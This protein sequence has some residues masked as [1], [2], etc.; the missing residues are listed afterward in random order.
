ME[1]TLLGADKIELIK[2]FLSPA[3]YAGI[4]ERSYR[5]ALCAVEDD[6]L[7]G[8]GIFDAKEAAVIHDIIVLD[9]L[10]GE[11]E[12]DIIHQICMICNVL[13]CDGVTMDVY[14]SDDRRILDKA[15]TKEGF[16]P[17]SLATIYSFYLSD[18]NDNPIL[19]K[20]KP[21][22]NIFNLQDV[23]DS[24]K[25]AF[26]NELKKSSIYDRFLDQDHDPY[27]SVVRTDNNS[28]TGCV[29]VD[30]LK[31]EYGFELSFLYSKKNANPANLINM[32]GAALDNVLSTYPEDC[33]GYITAVNEA[34]DDLVYKILPE[35]MIRD[36]ISR[37][38]ISI[39]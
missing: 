33:I 17:V 19:S 13:G 14:S 6:N 25:R 4:L 34:S 21:D 32:M 37:Y 15:L 16:L 27:M 36:Q 2:G 3:D 5:Y 18:L 24:M 39:A 12:S 22:K 8:V 9:E 29:L 38:A 31:N 11:I 7:S 35:A 30:D 28:I 10:R 1:Y 23:G 20:A 26:S